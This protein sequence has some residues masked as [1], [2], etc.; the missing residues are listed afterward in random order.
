MI[1]DDIT[2]FSR[3]VRAKDDLY[4]NGEISYEEHAKN[5]EELRKTL[6][7][8]KSTPVF[9]K[10]YIFFIL[11]LSPLLLFD[12]RIGRVLTLAALPTLIFSF[13][14]VLDLQSKYN[15]KVRSIYAGRS[16]GMN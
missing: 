12:D 16:S 14:T 6:K 3:L 10:Y 13:W 7:Y 15:L 5:G 9:I 1:D 4:Y 8:P 2:I 11:C